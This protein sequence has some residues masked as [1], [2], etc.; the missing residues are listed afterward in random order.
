MYAIRSYYAGPSIDPNRVRATLLRY[1]GARPVS[2]SK[3]GNPPASR[4]SPSENT[5]RILVLFA[6]PA[7]QKSYNFV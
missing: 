4:M 1:P 7:F 2:H 5:I 6:H 3:P